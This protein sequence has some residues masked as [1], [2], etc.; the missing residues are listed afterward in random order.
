MRIL[1][2]WLR[3]FVNVAADDRQLAE[4]LTSAGIAV[5]SVIAEN[6]ATVYEMDLT[7]NRVDAMNHYG[8]AREASAIYDVELKPIEPKLLGKTAD[9][10]APAAK[11][12][13][14]PVG[15][16][17][18]G[19]PIVIEDPQGC[20]RYSARVVRNV[21]IGP[22]PQHVA[23][24][25]ELIGSRSINNVAD[26]TNYELNELGHP[27]HAFDLDRLEG[28]T[29]IVRR[30]REGEVLK[31]LD[32]VDREL[33]T[34]DLVI[35]DAGK[36]VA[37][38]GVM[39][40][41]DSMITERTK[42]VLIES[43][44][45]HPATIRSMAKRHGMHTDASHRFER[46]ADWGIT[47]LACDRVTELILE[48]AGGELPGGQ[49]DVVARIL[50]P[51]PI[52]LRRSEVRRILGID[53]D[54]D[55]IQRTLVSLG[56]GMT[57]SAAGNLSVRIPTWR[58]DVERE[59]DLLEELARIHGYN[60]FPN[61]LPSFTG[62]VVTLPDEPKNAKVRE[63]MLALGY[64]EA[65]SITFTSEEDAKRFGGGE[66]LAIANP[67][68]EEAGYMRASVLPG[69]LNMVSYN[70]NRG[71]NNVRLFEAGEVFE[72]LGDG[73][74]E[75]RH[76]GFAATGDAFAKSVHTPSQPYTFFHI[77]GDVEEL[78]AAFQ[79]SSLYVDAQMPEYFHPGR[80]ARAVMDGKTVA[81]F[82]QLHPDL[83]SARKFRQD[84]YMAEV[85]L[86]RLYQHELR[87][88]CYQSISKFPAVERDF[89]FVFDDSVNFERIR[90]AVEEL[91]ILDL[92]N[93]VPAEIYRGEKVGA[94]K[95]S[96]LLHAEFQSKER[97]LRDDEVAQWSSQI[98]AK[99]ES[100]G[101]VLRAQ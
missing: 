93:F 61:T 48:N 64:D 80:S 42:N 75:H 84:V 29:I 10:S 66:P 58:L 44:W 95:Y 52:E 32:G 31:T 101:G 76:L 71:N 60:R 26:A 41:F 46:G 74:D 16:T 69:L 1:P 21:K 85:L 8:V 7:T 51:A 22:S 53:L 33:T 87:E 81:H 83:A 35:A 17:K 63:T 30:A 14:P 12:G 78:L 43:A 72:K 6:G 11:S 100:L 96:V 40:G 92:Q 27:T 65:I 15:M 5:E 20:A 55:E 18:Q 56:F 4:D 3:E 91:G 28:G 47:P 86:D 23:R 36:P 49:I 97:T 89:S 62:A 37:L 45:F 54:E 94:G 13:P 67:Q 73:G 57:C 50:D 19:F 39:G 68:S 79:H 2:S 99:L 82:G 70:L 34:D 38:A 9:P 59:V 24:R 25:L 90:S 98:I 77:K 88:P